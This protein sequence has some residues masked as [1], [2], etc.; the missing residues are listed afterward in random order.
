M[1]VHSSMGLNQPCSTM[2]CA[3]FTCKMLSPSSVISTAACSSYTV[4]RATTTY[5]MS[6]CP[7]PCVGVGQGT[8]VHGHE[9]SWPVHPLL[10]RPSPE[11][12]LPG[13]PPLHRGPPQTGAGEPETGGPDAR[14]QQGYSRPDSRAT[15]GPQQGHSRT[16]AAQT[17]GPQHPKQQGHSR[18][19]SRATAG[20]TAGPQQARQQGLHS[21]STNQFSL[22]SRFK[23]GSIY[24]N[25]F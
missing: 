21:E 17:A 9:H 23:H 4:S 22:S 11:T 7:S 6:T 12:G 2:V 1:L 24:R 5:P 16:T 18:P 8:A 3:V 13:D 20:Q 19:N 10:N 14:P 15:A 25:M